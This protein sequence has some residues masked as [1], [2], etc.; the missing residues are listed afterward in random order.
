MAEYGTVEWHD[1]MRTGVTEA[2]EQLTSTGDHEVPGYDLVPNFG[3]AISDVIEGVVKP[4]FLD[5]PFNRAVHN[6]PWTNLEDE[7][8][9]GHWH[10]LTVDEVIADPEYASDFS[11]G[12][13]A[14]YAR[15]AP[16]IDE[17]TVRVLAHDD[18]PGVRKALAENRQS[19]LDDVLEV[20]TQDDDEKVRMEAQA[21]LKSRLRHASKD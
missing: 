16:G 10:S 15:N 6:L 1:Q 20:L 5:G 13:R 17:T 2:Y 8:Y 19:V 21:A 12:L 4:D 18:H 14:V 9:A 3:E 11:A 7:E